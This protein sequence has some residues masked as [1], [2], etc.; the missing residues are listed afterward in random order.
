MRDR[1]EQ[2]VLHGSIDGFTPEEALAAVLP[3]CGLTFRR[4][5]ERLIVGVDRKD[6]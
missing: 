4:E 6:Q 3:T 1:I 5:G 2:I